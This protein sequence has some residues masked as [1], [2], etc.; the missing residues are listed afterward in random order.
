MILVSGAA[1]KKN[2]PAVADGLTPMRTAPDIKGFQVLNALLR[3]W[4]HGAEVYGGSATERTGP[5]LRD[6]VIMQHF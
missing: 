3:D 5:V 2:H 4:D 6:K 1:V